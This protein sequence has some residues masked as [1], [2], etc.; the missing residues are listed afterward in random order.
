MKFLEESLARFFQTCTDL[1]IV[2]AGCVG[3]FGRLNKNTKTAGNPS[4]KIS[5]R[6][7]Y[8]STMVRHTSKA[9][10]SPLIHGSRTPPAIRAAPV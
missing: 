4:E 5:C 10:S 9:V 3:M 6:M 8:S 1:L 7:L 2:C